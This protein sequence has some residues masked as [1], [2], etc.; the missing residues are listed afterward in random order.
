MPDWCR[1]E[2]FSTLSEPIWRE[3]LHSLRRPRSGLAR[4]G[5]RAPDGWVAVADQAASGAAVVP[6]PMSVVH[7]H[8][9]ALVDGM[10]VHSWHTGR[11][12]KVKV[13]EAMAYGLAVVTTPAG[14]EGLVL[15]AGEG[16]AIAAPRDF[17]TTLASVL[18]SPER[19]ARLGA[20]GRA[21]IQGHHSPVASARARLAAIAE[22]FGLP[23]EPEPASPHP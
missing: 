14:V 11:D 12:H 21:A 5:W 17:A 13:V 6:C 3:H 19:R 10:A 2:P 23:A 1:Y 15:A 8:Y 7:L 22:A 20:S 18:A 4:A 16:A 9:R